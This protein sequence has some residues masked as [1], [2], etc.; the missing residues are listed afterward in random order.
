MPLIDLVIIKELVSMRQVNMIPLVGFSVEHLKPLGEVPLEIT[1]REGALARTK[2]LTSS[3]LGTVYLIYSAGRVEDA[4]KKFKESSP[5]PPKKLLRANTDVFAWTCS[6]MKGAPRTLMID[7]KPFHTKHNLNEY[8]HINHIKQ[9]RR[10]LALKSNVATCREVD[11][12][13]QAK[14]LREVKYQTYVANPIMV[15]KSNS[16]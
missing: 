7:G 13:T 3:L 4:C 2:P 11:E 6:N 5:E 16:S 9:K 12:L 10:G 15:K 1:I 14:I 8:K